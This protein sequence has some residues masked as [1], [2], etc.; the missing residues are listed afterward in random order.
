[1]PQPN[2]KPKALVATPEPV[3]MLVS[4]I[5]IKDGRAQSPTVR[6]P[7]HRPNSRAKS[8]GM[9]VARTII[10]DPHQERRVDLTLAGPSHKRKEQR[11]F[12]KR[13]GNRKL[14]L[15]QEVVTN[16]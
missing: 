15:K 10:P 7:G 4:Y 3:T 12:G 9:S 2:A 16:M 1:M 8:R 13:L 14:K 11:N 6:S 5:S